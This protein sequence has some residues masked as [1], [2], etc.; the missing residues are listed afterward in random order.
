MLQVEHLNVSFSLPTRWGWRTHKSYRA[1]DDVELTLASGETLGIVGES[2]S[3]KTTLARSIV[4]LVKPQSGV[5][6]FRGV[7]I[8]TLPYTEMR[9]LREKMQIIFQDP[10]ASLNPRMTLLDIVAEPLDIC[11]PCTKTEREDC[12]SDL[13]K[14]VGLAPE[15]LMRY[16]H[17]LSGGQR[18]RIGIAR[19]MILRPELV[20]ADEPVSAL[21]QS[22]QSQVMELLSEFRKKFHV[23]YLFISHDLALVSRFADRIAVM[24][25]GRIIEEAASRSLLQAPLH[26]YTQT[27]LAATP[28]SHPK[29]RR[30]PPAWP[31]FT[32]LCG[33]APNERPHLV[34]AQPGHRV[35]CHLMGD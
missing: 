16:P 21:D 30:S 5:V 9:R 32:P 15:M 4:R 23:G 27:L 14:Q 26:P 13:L 19:A 3:G 34:E 31:P 25:R 24:Y 8:L 18:Q 7:D 29:A 20:M 12:V 6:R 28:A 22:V 2:G 35:S 33:H 11:R 17:E 1:V 10:Y